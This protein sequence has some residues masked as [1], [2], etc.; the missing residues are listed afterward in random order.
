MLGSCTRGRWLIFKSNA[1][2]GNVNGYRPGKSRRHGLF[3]TRVIEAN[4][5]L[6]ERGATA[7]IALMLWHLI[8]CRCVVH[9]HFGV[10]T[11][12]LDLFD[13]G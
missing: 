8:M 4:N 6:Q 13:Q 11:G 1:V 10:M 2:S 7:C 9:G 3:K 12:H 5:R